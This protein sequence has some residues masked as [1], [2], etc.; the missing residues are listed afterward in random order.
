M[1]DQ[2]E[3]LKGIKACFY[4]I[5]GVKKFIVKPGT[6]FFLQTDHTHRFYLDDAAGEL[7]GEN[8]KNNKATASKAKWAYIIAS[9][10]NEVEKIKGDEVF[11]F[12]GNPNTAGADKQVKHMGIGNRY[13]EGEFMEFLPAGNNFWIGSNYRMEVFNNVPGSG[14]Y[15]TFMPVSKP[16]IRF[17]YFDKQNFNPEVDSL[18]INDGLYHY[19]QTILLNM[20][21][22]LFLVKY[23]SYYHIETEDSNENLELEVI[24]TDELHNPLLDKPIVSDKLY[25]FIKTKTPSNLYFE[26][27]IYIDPKWK[28]TIHLKKEV[29]KLYSATIKIKNKE[30]K[31]EYTYNVNLS[32]IQKINQDSRKVEQ[33]EVSYLMLVKYESADTL[34]KNQ[35][36][37]KNNQ[38][39]YIGD[40]EYKHKEY[41]PCGYAK[42]TIE[43]EGS[44]TREP[45][46]TFDEDAAV[47]DRTNLSFDIIAGDKKKKVLIKLDKLKNKGVMCTGVLLEKGQQHSDIRNVFQMQKVVLIQKNAQGQNV[48]EEDQTHQKQ[49]KAAGVK[50]TAEN[51]TDYDYKADPVKRSAGVAATQHLKEGVDYQYVGDDMKLMPNYN[52]NKTI[53]EDVTGF[54]VIDDFANK[55]LWMFR[56][57]F[58]GDN[59][60]Q[61]Y[62]IPI[63]SCRYPNQLA[64]I[65]VFPDIKWKVS[66]L[67]S[68]KKTPQ[69]Y[70][71]TGMPTGVSKTKGETR[72][73]PADKKKDIYR[74]SV[75]KANKATNKRKIG[76]TTFDFDLNLSCTE[77]GI[78]H[79]LAK[80]IAEKVAKFMGM[81]VAIKEA[82]DVICHNDQKH[83]KNVMS[84]L[85]V[86]KGLPVYIKFDYPT[87]KIDGSW[88]YAAQPAPNHNAVEASGKITIGLEPLIRGEGGIDL[89]ALALLAAKGVFVV[90]QVLWALEMV[91]KGV[92]FV[93]DWRGYEVSRKLEL[94]VYT[95]AQIDARVEI[96]INTKEYIN[97]QVDGRLGIGAQLKLEAG[98][99]DKAIVM[100]ADTVK[101]KKGFGVAVDAKGE[102]YVELVAIAGIEK[103]PG[104][105]VFV[106]P[107]VNFG[108]VKLTIII[109]TVGRTGKMDEAVQRLND[110]IW[111]VKKIP[112]IVEMRRFYPFS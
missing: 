48:V 45:F 30:T 70:S 5:D 27:P 28:N 66:V 8:T 108:G 81:F 9:F 12:W 58:L 55:K 17:A 112:D 40:V 61:T 23:S 91:E 83:A 75:M 78:T 10:W 69:S 59:K 19:G 13:K 41:D 16:H 47:I 86:R 22:H 14:L 95:F 53:A 18:G 37:R 1:D 68:D 99:V 4:S 38:I 103:G 104:K 62:F 33:V 26:I 89:I 106:E 35:E 63:G 42:I 54:S 90:S 101:P 71:S 97:M 52:Y 82:V 64:K 11:P 49:L 46:D 88:E 109:K 44:K 84:K 74:E 67:I 36:I 57:L 100:E 24:L 98:V 96:P 7:F 21:T 65:R 92:Q 105:G 60:A 56:Y 76:S 25:K 3:I 111:V 79:E 29:E 80:N 39:Q 87:I 20:S 102:S 34:L 50:V 15:F 93:A 73:H 51:K 94:N 77:N 107:K 43:E 72:Y 6:A 110:P 85:P 31:K 32:S 2:K